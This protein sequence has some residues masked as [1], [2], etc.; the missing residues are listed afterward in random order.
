M[1]AS[2]GKKNYLL[3][4]QRNIWVFSSCASWPAFDH[5]VACLPRFPGILL[6][7]SCLIPTLIKTRQILALGQTKDSDSPACCLWPWP[8]MNASEK[9]EDWCLHIVILSKMCSK[10]V[11]GDL[12]SRA[13]GWAFTNT[14]HISLLLA[15]LVPE[16]SGAPSRHQDASSSTPQAPHHRSSV[17]IYTPLFDVKEGGESWALLVPQWYFKSTRRKQSAN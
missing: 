4:T 3:K 17:A 5:F 9:H 13:D 7:Y 14:H 11:L 6:C 15:Q 10:L 2:K 12:R 1:K 16:S 8:N